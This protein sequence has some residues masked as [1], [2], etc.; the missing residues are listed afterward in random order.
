MAVKGPKGP[1]QPSPRPPAAPAGETPRP[2]GVP[3]G[4]RIPEDGEHRRRQRDQAAQDLTGEGRIGDPELSAEAFGQL[5]TLVAA[6]HLMALLAR[7]RRDL[8]RAALLDEVGA[9]L[10]AQRDPQA[11]RRILLQMG[12]VGRIVDIYPLEVMDWVLKRRPE[13]LGGFAYGDVI[14]NKAELGSRTFDVEE[15]IRIKVP[16]SL[17][18]RAFAL[19]GGGAPGYCF[20][21]GPPAE[22]HLE[23]AEAGR[24]TILVRGDVRRTSLLD[25]AILSI[26]EGPDPDRKW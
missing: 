20:A 15:V 8:P 2:L 1:G 18:M 7:R 10:L 19:E 22:Y 24:Y 25:R 6:R 17:K 14:L 9:L 3:L 23:I 26:E 13:L 11:I 12:E 16:L 5:G 21:P 4:H